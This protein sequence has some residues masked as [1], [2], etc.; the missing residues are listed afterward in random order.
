MKT[1]IT[2]CEVYD[3]TNVVAG[4]CHGSKWIDRWEVSFV[5]D[6]KEAAQDFAKSADE[7]YAGLEIKPGIAE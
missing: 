5:F 1:R 4:R 6:S 7:V 3:G 2:K